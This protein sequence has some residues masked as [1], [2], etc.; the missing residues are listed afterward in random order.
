VKLADTS[1]FIG[2]ERGWALG[3]D[4]ILSR[5]GIVLRASEAIASSTSERSERVATEGSMAR[6]RRIAIC[7]AAGLAC[8]GSPSPSPDAPRG[9]TV[10]TF[11]QTGL[12][13]PNGIATDGAQ[14]YATDGSNLRRIGIA[15]QEV[16]TLGTPAW[17]V[18]LGSE[19]FSGPAGVATDGTWVY[20]AD[21]RTIKRVHVASGTVSTL[22]GDGNYGANDG[23]GQA[24]RFAE[25][26]G[27][28]LVGGALYVADGINGVRRVELSSGTVTTLAALPFAQGMAADTAS[29]LVTDDANVYRV[30]LPGGQVELLGLV[31]PDRY[32]VALL[33]GALFVVNHMGGTVQRVDLAPF[34]VVDIAGGSGS[35]STDGPGADARFSSPFGL[36][37]DGT[38][39]YVADWGNGSIRK[40]APPAP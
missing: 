9:W 2:Y 21:A 18:A 39:L 34:A 6:A 20:V 28:A 5:G 25:P 16:S 30:S 26:W 19:Y 11:A 29:L 1:L 14:L 32:G 15:T 24:A 13:A 31:G 23:V 10:T 22:A 36:A 35:G 12:Q 37:S 8:S 7:A 38:S 4:K 33:G 40:L 3:V 17:P 27:L